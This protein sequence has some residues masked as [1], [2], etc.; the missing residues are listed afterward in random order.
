MMTQDGP[1]AANPFA[2]V[3]NPPDLPSSDNRESTTEEE[4]KSVQNDTKMFGVK[5]LD[6]EFSLH[7]KF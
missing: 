3:Y 7:G 6:D 2:K 1:I 4:P 5:Q